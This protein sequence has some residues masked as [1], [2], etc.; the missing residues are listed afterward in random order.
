MVLPQIILVAG[1]SSG[2]GALT[3]SHLAR[4]G[5][6]VYASMPNPDQEAD[7]SIRPFVA[8]HKCSLRPLVLDVSEESSCQSAVETIV[9]NSGHLDT[10]VHNAGE[11]YRH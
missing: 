8:E 10:I 1:A 6:I 3:A 2:F 7:D 4:A 11:E 9:K 5:H